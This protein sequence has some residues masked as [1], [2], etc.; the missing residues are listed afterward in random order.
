M[1]PAFGGPAHRSRKRL[2]RRRGRRDDRGRL[3][4]GLS[5]HRLA[6]CGQALRSRRGGGAPHRRDR[7]R[8]RRRRP[9]ARKAESRPLGLPGGVRMTGGKRVALGLA[10]WLFAVTALHSV[11][12]VN[13]AVLANDFLAPDKRKLNVAYIPV[14]CHLACP[15]TDYR[16]EEHT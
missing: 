1:E 10:A 14:T 2:A 4:P 15:V 8:P 12:N 9:A 11:L 6:K 13:W 16:S 7:P 3:G 5:H